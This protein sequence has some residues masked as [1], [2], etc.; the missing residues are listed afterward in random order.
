M[1]E[2]RLDEVALINHEL[3][4]PLWLLNQ[5]ERQNLVQIAA[6]GRIEIAYFLLEVGV[7]LLVV[8]D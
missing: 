1:I 7:W 8:G 3:Q 5:P 4:E 2:E 6:E